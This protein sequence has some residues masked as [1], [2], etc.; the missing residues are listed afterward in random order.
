MPRPVH[1]DRGTLKPV[2]FSRSRVRLNQVRG[3]AR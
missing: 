3:S 1:T 2:V